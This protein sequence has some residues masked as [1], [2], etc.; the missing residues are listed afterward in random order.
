MGKIHFVFITQRWWFGMGVVRIENFRKP[1][2]RA[3]QLIYT[4]WGFRYGYPTNIFDNKKKFSLI[5]SFQL[6]EKK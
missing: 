6:G 3:T 4:S 2:A 1:D 5:H